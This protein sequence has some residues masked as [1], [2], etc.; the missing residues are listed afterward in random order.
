VC[1]TPPPFSALDLSRK[2]PPKPHT[3]TRRP[4]HSRDQR[5]KDKQHKDEND[6]RSYND[7]VNRLADR[8]LAR[9]FP[10]IPLAAILEGYGDFSALPAYER[11]L[12]CLFFTS[13]VTRSVQLNLCFLLFSH[14]LLP[15]FPPRNCP[16]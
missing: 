16:L 15:A 2:V 13:F 5:D 4:Y 6:L 14:L 7:I 1:D 11:T 8:I 3:T 10:N 9:P 12:Q